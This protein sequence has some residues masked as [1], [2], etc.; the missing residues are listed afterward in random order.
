MLM[1]FVKNKL[2]LLFFKRK[3]RKANS[4]NDTHAGNLFNMGAV[5]VGRY[6]YG[7]INAHTWNGAG[8]Q[9]SI[10]DYVS[11]AEN[12]TFLLGG[13]HHI[14]GFCTFPFKS[15]SRAL[16]PDTDAINK[17]GIIIGDDTWIGMNVIILSGVNIGRGCVVAAGSVVTKSF[18]PFSVIGGNPAK[19]IKYRLTGEEISVAES[20][21]LKKLQLEKLTDQQLESLY[22]SPTNESL[23][24]LSSI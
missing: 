16:D 13:N 17:G 15:K 12:V 10:G 22:K 14:S 24:P 4:H 9:L 8:E 5:S 18:P 20:L 6:S 3:Y 19:L 1:S 11:I 7:V 21:D 2:K 23:K